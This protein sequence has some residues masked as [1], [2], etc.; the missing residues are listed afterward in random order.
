MSLV[1]NPA[2]RAQNLWLNGISLCPLDATLPG[3]ITR[4]IHDMRKRHSSHTVPLVQEK[5][6]LLNNLWMDG[7]EADVKDYFFANIFPTP[8]STQCIG[9]D[10]RCQMSRDTV[11]G[12]ET[13]NSKIS[14]PCPD[15]LYVY[16]DTA[17]TDAQRVQLYSIG[18]PLLAN[19][20]NALYP[21]FY[22]EAEGDS[23]GERGSLWVATNQCLGGS[24]SCIRIAED[25]NQKLRDQVC[26]LKEF[27][28]YFLEESYANV[29]RGAQ[30]S[31][32]EEEGKTFQP[33]D[34]TI[35]SAAF[36]GTE[37]RLYVSWKDDVL[38]KYYMASMENFLI[39]RPDHYLEFQ[40]YV[41]N[42]VDWGR[43]QRLQ[44]I[45]D[46]LDTLISREEE[47]KKEESQTRL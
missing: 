16:K 12:P 45:R 7:P 11:P 41:L 28:F 4:L 13:G 30:I 36:N 44:S 29:G 42:I 1:E 20:Q 22:I 23:S 33:I 24:V 43:G 25:L 21:F 19:N 39:H 3:H 17:F 40:K 47:G 46:A 35:F 5:M 8:S 9:R 38:N 6:N 37:A 26:V 15:M 27:L 10:Q 18:G 31:T 14:T 2:Y 32:E 34:H